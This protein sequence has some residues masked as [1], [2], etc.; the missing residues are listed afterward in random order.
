MSEPVSPHEDLTG[1]Q[2]MAAFLAVLVAFVLE[3]ADSTIVNTALPQ[4]KAGLGGG[5]SAM[6][7]IAAAYFLSLGSFLLIGGRLGDIYGYR[8]VFLSGIGAFTLA[9]CLCGLARNAEELVAARF[10]QGAA[11]ALMAPQVMAIVQVLFTP[12]ERVGKLAWF[13]VIGGLASILGP[14][15]GGLLIE[16]D[17]MGLGWRMIFLINLPIGLLAIAAAARFVPDMRQ[18]P[19][20]RIDYAGAALFVVAFALLLLALIEGPE[21]RWPAWTIAC[22]AAGLALVRIG[23]R[24]ARGRIAN[25]RTGIIAPDLFRLPTYGWGVAAVTV[26]SGAASGFLLVFAISLQQGL[27]LSALDTA[28][29]HVPFGFGVMGGISLI[30]RH[31]LPRYGKWLIIAGAAVMASTGGLALMSIA[32][33][34]PGDAGLLLLLGLAGM[35]MGMV[36]G[37][38]PPVVMADVERS[39]AGTAS[40][41]MRTAQQIGGA[42]GIALIG[43][44]YF[45]VGQGTAAARLEGLQPAGLVFILALIATGMFALRLPRNI[46]GQ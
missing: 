29:L 6:Q 45:S 31:Y 36:M 37:P 27:G 15:L 3:V 46:F 13:G 26:F 35:G 12:L 40:A 8:R 18:N 38:L 20:Q 43:A 5:Q 22:A 11:G 32:G 23:W 24:H 10:F 41:M 14:I 34:Q 39:K 21:L 33:G 30:G 42:A 19:D 44:A 2:K 16:A 9:S 25:G 4:I 7:W 17:F 1:F 28:L